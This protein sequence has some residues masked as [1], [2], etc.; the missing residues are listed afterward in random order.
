MKRLILCLITLALNLSAG[1]ISKSPNGKLSVHF[2]L[3]NGKPSYSISFKNEKVIK[4]SY[5]GFD[6]KHQ[7]DLIENFTISDITLKEFKETWEQPWG[8]DR[9]IE[10]HYNEIGISFFHQRDKYKASIR[11]VRME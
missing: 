9:F 4:P 7:K 2:D 11:V 6:L 3:K 5:L 8:E 10:N 1:E